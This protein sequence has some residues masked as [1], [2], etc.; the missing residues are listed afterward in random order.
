VTASE[1][2]LTRSKRQRQRQ[3]QPLRRPHEIATTPTDRLEPSPSKATGVRRLPTTQSQ[4]PRERVQAQTRLN[5][6]QRLFGE[7]ASQS[8]PKRRRNELSSSIA[9]QKVTLFPQ[10]QRPQN[11][12]AMS[13]TVDRMPTTARS[14]SVSPGESQRK[15]EAQPF[16]ETNGSPSPQAHLTASTAAPKHRASRVRLSRGN[17]FSPKRRGHATTSKQ[18]SVKPRLSSP[19]SA[20]PKPKRRVVAPLIYGT[21]LL[22]LGI[23][24]GVVVGTLL[25]IGNPA[26]GDRKATP[27]TNPSEIKNALAEAN[28]PPTS[29]VSDRQPLKLSQEIAPLKIAVASLVEKNPPLKPAVFIIDL[30]TG[31]Y[32]DWNGGSALASASTIKIPILVAF[33]QDVDAGKIRLD[34]LLTMEPGFIATGSGNMQHKHPGTKYTALA[35]ATKMIT[36]SDNTATNMLIARLGGEAALNQRFREWGLT[37]TAIRNR[38][39]DVEGTNTTSPKDLATLMVQVNQGE[40]VSIKSRDRLLDIMRRTERNHLLPRGLGEG[41]TIAHKTGNIG[42]MVADAGLIDLPS[43]KRYIAA[44]MVKRPRN[45][46]Q[47]ETL[48]R[49]ISRLAYQHFNQQAATPTTPRE[50]DKMPDNSVISPAEPIQRP[51]RPSSTMAGH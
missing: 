48:I 40:L 13:S 26:I 1:N 49:R 7:S 39:P 47:A 25:S 16:P 51:E 10:P 23:G 36:I 33:F 5:W 27:T 29:P 21:R 45:D 8:P 32:L 6:W 43:G 2:H 15:R 44:V 18:T 11:R 37:T 14:R 24:L 19:I 50:S 12:R 9:Q 35:T 17:Q 3:Q 4:R 31:A 20:K 34:E 42:A 38:L 28:L 41:A 30:D 46:L 22:I